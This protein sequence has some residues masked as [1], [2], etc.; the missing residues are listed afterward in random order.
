MAAWGLVVKASVRV[1]VQEID[2]DDLFEGFEG[3]YR[4]SREDVSALARWLSGEDPLAD[5][6]AEEVEELA[7]WYISRRLDPMGRRTRAGGR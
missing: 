6:S 5:L 2:E 7:L 1:T 4:A 3:G